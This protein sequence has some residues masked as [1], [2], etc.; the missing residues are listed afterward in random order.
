[1]EQYRKID[2]VCNKGETPVDLALR[3]EDHQTATLLEKETQSRDL[4]KEVGPRCGLGCWRW[5]LRI[6]VLVVFVGYQ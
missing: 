6:V 3:M 5:S 1:M 4:R 2:V